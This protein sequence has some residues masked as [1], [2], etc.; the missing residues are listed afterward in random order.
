VLAAA[1]AVA[2][3]AAGCG[4]RNG[5]DNQSPGA[6]TRGGATTAAGTGSGDFGD[7]KGV[8]QPGT[9]SSAPAQGVTATQ[10]KVGVFSDVGFTKNPEF[11]DAAKAFTSWCNAAGG[12]NGRKLVADTLDSKLLEVRQRMAEAC[13]TD[14]A[15]VGGGAALDGL[16][17]RDRLSCLLPSFPGQVT[18]SVSSDLQVSQTGGASYDRYAGYFHWLVK[19]AYPAA[20]GSLG[21]IGGDSPV[22][23]LINAT[24]IEGVTHAGGTLV[25]NNLYPATGTS[26]WTPYAQALKRKGVRGLIFDGDFLS[27]SK[28]E[29]ALSTAG[30][31]L[32]WI[33]ANA[34]AY[35]PAFIQL[36]GPSLAT[37]NNLADISGVAPLEAAGSN[38]ATQQVID[39][40][41]QY[42]GGAP[43]TLPA[44]GAFAA[45]VL[46][47]RSAASCG[48][49]LTR[50]CVYDA[51]LKQTAFTAGG[52]HAPIDLSNQDAPLTCFNVERATPA[53]W[54]P[55]DFKPDKGVYRCNGPTYK[56]TGPYPKP[57]TLADVGKS[58]DDVK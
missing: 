2:L 14:F 16:G 47:A 57:M 58:L 56:F 9:S 1:V 25:Y 6:D 5:T 8:C 45:W 12:I 41:K 52:L 10:I 23:K 43:V 15:L 13:R 51:A 30:Y 18:Q 37:Q 29:Q 19:E 3:L 11:V 26:D 46:F 39:L 48:D 50:R 32:D 4:G 17:T 42:A 33:D 34:N 28:L 54:Q 38:P 44:L 31:K 22:T 27:L 40:F 35:T 36:A 55:A 49:N 21:F 53:G 7:L 24:A 20:A